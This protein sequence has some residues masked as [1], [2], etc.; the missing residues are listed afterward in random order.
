MKIVDCAT[1]GSQIASVPQAQSMISGPSPA[2]AR[3]PSIPSFSTD[4]T[5]G[6]EP[7]RSVFRSDAILGMDGNGVE[8]T[9][10]NPGRIPPNSAS[11]HNLSPPITTVTCVRVYRYRITT[12]RIKWDA[13]PACRCRKKIPEGTG[14]PM[15]DRPSQSTQCS[16][17]SMLPSTSVLTRR[18]AGS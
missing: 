17:A 12:R 11:R 8:N 14:R 10:R 9:D 16:P 18:P 15:A 6:Q 7:A 1:L 2:E 13:L 4:I 5:Q 3:E